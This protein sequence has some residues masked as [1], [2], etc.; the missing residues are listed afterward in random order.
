MDKRGT[1]AVTA[2]V[3]FGTRVLLKAELEWQREHRKELAADERWSVKGLSRRDAAAMRAAWRTELARLREEGELL[4]SVDRL[5]VLGIREELRARGWERRWPTVPEEA[6]DPGRW[7][8]SRGGAYPEAVPLRL[9]APLARQVR[10][11]CWHTSA[12]AIGALRDWRDAN[13]GI[14]PGRSGELEEYERLAAQV[15]TVGDVWRGGLRR[16][17]EAAKD[18]RERFAN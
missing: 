17:L 6:L 12:K 3:P 11:A 9:S 14:V 1:A 8:G 16:G 7:P 18:M 2:K 15:T 5:A 4:D 13:P 10:G